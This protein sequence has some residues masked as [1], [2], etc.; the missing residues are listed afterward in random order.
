M[1]DAPD[2]RSEKFLSR[3]SRRKQAEPEIR[4]REDSRVSDELAIE[5]GVTPPQPAPVQSI[6]ADLPAVETLT[7]D[8]DFSRFMRADVPAATR[9]AAM[10]KLFGDPH[11]NLMDGL[12]IYIDD[13]SKA[14]PIPL[15]M[16][17]D[18]AQSRM[19]HLFDDD[20]EKLAPAG[21]PATETVAD[22]PAAGV[23]AA[24]TAPAAADSNPAIDPDAAA[25]SQGEFAAGGEI[26][27]PEDPARKRGEL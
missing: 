20:E 14:D 15:A 10:K 24:A 8:A 27:A 3:W 25:P 23:L 19:L 7:A 6:P 26:G 9:N 12:D 4:E 1:S 22:A 16:L 5:R 2:P 21:L 13:Y 18:L 17:K 11:F